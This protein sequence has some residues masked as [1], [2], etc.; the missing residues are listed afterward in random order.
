MR[1]LF[2]STQF[3]RDCSRSV[4]GGFQRMRMW[5]DAIQSLG[6]ELDILFFPGP[7]DPAAPTPSA[8]TIR[9][10]L[11]EQWGIDSHVEVCERD[12]EDA[13][14]GNDSRLAEYFDAYIRPAFGPSQHPFF[15]PFLGERQRAAL[16]RGLARDPA[17]ALFH[18]LQT[19]VP[20]KSLPA[21]GTRFL[22]DLQDLEHLGFA[23]E[24][25]Q[26]PR[27][28]LKPLL[29]LQVP[30]LWW[31]ERAAIV[32]SHRTFVCSENDRRYLRRTMAVRNVDVIPNAVA[33][34]ADGTLTAEPTVVYLGTYSYRP[35]VVAAE[36]LIREVWPSVRRRCPRAR[37]L[38]AGPGSEAIDGFSVPPPGVEFLG[39]VDDLD[40]LYR[41]SRVV[42]CPIQSGTGTRT[43]ILEAASYGVPVVSTSVGAEGLALIPEAEI[44]L[45]DTAEGLAEACVGLITDEGHATRI[46]TA[47]REAVRARYSRDGVLGRMRAVLT[48]A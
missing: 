10:Q 29:Y 46:R 18:R 15:R 5:L 47:A 17:V 24:V 30:A 48:N 11:H 22:F 1:V 35:N 3:P 40:A 21:N 33:R 4:Y 37:L 38:I 7:G 13:G 27:W 14:H 32:R 34:V 31:G 2:V 42:C 28:R 41:R 36:Y 26:P 43:K 39:F 44:L 25:A 6:A 45:R 20:A 16:A 23:R 9:R 12:P 19:T 8:E